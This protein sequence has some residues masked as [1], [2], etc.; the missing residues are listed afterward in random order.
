[1]TTRTF[2]YNSS[3][4]PN[5]P[6]ISFKIQSKINGKWKDVKSTGR[7]VSVKVKEHC[8]NIGLKLNPYHI[9]L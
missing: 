9:C 2:K 4:N 8:N 1:M 5:N 6:V 3:L 7:V